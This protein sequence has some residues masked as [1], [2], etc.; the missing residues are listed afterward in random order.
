MRVIDHLL[1]AK[2]P[3][4]SI[5][6][7]PPRRGGN[8]NK[9]HQ[10]IESVIPYNP[11]FVDVTSHA[12][13]V[14][15][16]EMPDGSFRKKVKRKSPGTF[17]LCANIK[18]RYNLEPVPHILCGGFTREETEDALIELNYLGIENILAI[19]GDKVN[20]RPIPQDRS[21]NHYAV[22]LVK[23]AEDMNRG[24]YLDDLIDAAKT[25]FCIGVACYPEKHFEAPNMDFELQVLK[26]KQD[27]GAHY[28]VTQMFF[29]TQKY[30][31]FVEKAKAAGITM[32]IIPGMKVMTSKG[33]LSRLPSFFHIDIPQE[34]TERM[35]AAKTRA[36]EIEVGV[37][38]AYRQS[39]ELLDAGIPY[40]HFYIM[41]NTNPFLKLMDKIRVTV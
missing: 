24:K 33:H 2:N 25:N 11:P 26:A 18:Y 23:Q 14:M 40:L 17:G 36:E 6:I 9:L 5:E 30:L 39:I 22:D 15:W 29:N 13:E 10:A 3:T 7:I 16:E 4:V 38:W 32:P 21:V 37:E 31:E 1:N 19:R 28:A 34:L 27:A 35:M 8:I 41:Q 12:A 20:P